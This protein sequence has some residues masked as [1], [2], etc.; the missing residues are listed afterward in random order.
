MQCYIKLIILVRYSSIHYLPIYVVCYQ[1]Q[2]CHITFLVKFFQGVT[3]KSE[4]SSSLA[5]Y[6]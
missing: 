5:L 6:V 3:P 2:P 4:T 1:E